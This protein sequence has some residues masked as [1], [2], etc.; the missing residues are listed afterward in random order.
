MP[1][2]KRVVESKATVGITPVTL[3]VEVL[4][5]VTF[6]CCASIVDRQGGALGKPTLISE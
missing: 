3:D 4:A 2:E 6:T 1:Q 5:E